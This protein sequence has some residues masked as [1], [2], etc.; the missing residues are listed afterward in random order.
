MLSALKDAGRTVW[1]VLAQMDSDYGAYRSSS[2]SH[3]LGEGQPTT[4]EILSGLLAE[5][6]TFGPAATEVVDLRSQGDL[7]PTDGVLI[8]YADR[9]RLIV[10]PSGTEPKVKF[11]LEAVGE[12]Q[13]A[14]KAL[15]DLTDVL[16][17]GLQAHTG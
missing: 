1:D 13:N 9:T 6:P 2:F 17:T 11:Y 7:P 14:E 12:P 8:R 4:E 16:Q 15:Q 10:R 5:P 3:R